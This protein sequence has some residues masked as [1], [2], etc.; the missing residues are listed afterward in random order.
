LAGDELEDTDAETQIATTFLRLGTWDDEPAD[1][2][3]DRYDQLDDVLATTSKT[4]LAMTMQCA[5]CHSHKFEPISQVDYSRMLAIFEPLRRPQD[6]RTDLDRLVGAPHEL[7]SYRDK[8]QRV[9]ATIGDRRQ[10]LEETRQRLRSIVLNEN[11]CQ[12]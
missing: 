12:L 6:G 1:N 11:R 9:E 7:D 4:F 3:V 10:R 8:L 5:R 2:L